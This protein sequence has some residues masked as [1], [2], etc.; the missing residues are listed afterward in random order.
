[1]QNRQ[2]PLGVLAQHTRLNLRIIQ[3]LALDRFTYGPSL[4]SPEQ[5]GCAHFR[6]GDLGSAGYGSDSGPEPS[7]DGPLNQSAPRE[8]EGRVG[9]RRRPN[10]YSGDA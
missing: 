5:F 2:D 8:T 4:G 10:Y 9:K 3:L 7:E 1:V 6:H